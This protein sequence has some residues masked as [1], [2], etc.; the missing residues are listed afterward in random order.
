[1]VRDGPVT[2]LRDFSLKDREEE[3][4]VYMHLFNDYLLVS[5]RKEYVWLSLTSI[6]QLLFLV[7]EK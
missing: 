4:N 5:L 1:M 2:E 7:F 6:L 3:R